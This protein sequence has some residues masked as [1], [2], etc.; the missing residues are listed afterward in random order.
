[1]FSFV[2]LSKIF[3]YNLSSLAGPAP[4]DGN[5]QSR[6]KKTVGRRSLPQQDPRGKG[7]ARDSKHVGSAE[8]R[9]LESF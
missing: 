2:I 8:L 4:N 6:S 3:E 7:E 1:M 5:G 9:G